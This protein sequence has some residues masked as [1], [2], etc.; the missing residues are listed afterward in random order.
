MSWWRNL[1]G[2]K[3]RSSLHGLKF[4]HAFTLYAQDGERAVE[5]REFE[6]GETYL[7]EKERIE[8]DVYKD[9]HSGKMVGPFVS[10]EQAERFIVTTPWF[11]G[12]GE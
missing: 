12:R 9:R 4:R 8:G 3:A 10:T 2:R 1:L 7:I 6:N 11:L 5:V